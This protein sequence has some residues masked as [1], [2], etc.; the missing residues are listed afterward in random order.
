MYTYRLVM[1]SLVIMQSKVQ[2]FLDTVS[3]TTDVVIANLDQGE[4]CNIM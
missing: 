3:I 1:I 4:V 2:T